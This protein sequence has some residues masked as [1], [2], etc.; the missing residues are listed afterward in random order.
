M[1]EIFAITT[2]LYYINGRPHIGHVYATCIADALARYHRQK[3]DEVWF[4]T[5]SDEHGQ[6]IAGIAK[7]HNM[8]PKAWADDI[9]AYTKELWDIFGMSYD[10]FVRTTEPQHHQDVVGV[11]DRVK[12]KGDIYLGKY[13]GWYSVSEERFLSEEEKAAYS[14]SDLVWTEEETFYFKL[15][16]YQQA[17]LEMYEKEPDRLRP[18]SRRNEILARLRGE[19]LRDLSITR[20]SIEWGIP[21]PNLK[22][23]HVCY[24][25]FDALLGYATA[26]GLNTD[27]D[28]FRRVWPHVVHLIGKDILWF[29]AVI[30]PAML[31]SA[32]IPL[33]KGIIAHGF[34]IK[35]EQKISK[36]KGNLIKAEPF[37]EEF[38]PDPFR[39]YLLRE[40]S[41]GSDG[42]FSDSSFIQRTNSDLAN[43]LGNALHRSLS[44]IQRYRD[45]KVPA[46]P[47]GRPVDP[48]VQELTNLAARVLPASDRALEEFLCQEALTLLWEFIRGINKYID[49]RAPWALSKQGDEAGLDETLY[50]MAD[51]LRMA[52]VAVSPYIPNIADGMWAQLGLPGSPEAARRNE[53][54][55]FGLL[56][57]GLVT[58]LGDPVVPRIDEKEYFARL[59]PQQGSE[60]PAIVIDRPAAA[61]SG[62]GAAKTGKKKSGEKGEIQYDD[63]GKLDLRV[64]E[65]VA[66]ER[67]EG[68]DKLLK[69]TIS[70]GESTRTIVS[71]IAEHYT[72]DAMVGRKIVVL[73]NLAPRKLRGVESQGMLLATTTAEGKVIV[74]TPEQDAPAGSP[75]S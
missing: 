38:G 39:Y 36:S 67:V 66:A 5:G 30:W 10:R 49:S 11:I 13:E 51:A 63:F 21:L 47:A 12:A 53:A 25:W 46:R 64:A 45:G 16:A 15:S 28:F 29:H 17:L 70:L 54:Y 65:V 48:A 40:S 24:V 74:L 9:V 43:D 42:S 52:A 8:A 41:L 19:A 22:P 37:L 33:S 20:T 60:A 34:W 7:A 3:G 68:A 59:V 56:P 1:A 57:G 23:G 61:P 35:D 58:R 18:E 44:M 75:V 31:L 69:L 14:G 62:N 55:T 73:A 27:K 72:P 71:G 26:C 6:K 32:G 50:D 2:P 4:V